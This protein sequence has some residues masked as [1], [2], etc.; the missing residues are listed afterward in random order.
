[1]VIMMRGFLYYLLA[2]INVP[3]VFAGG[4]VVLLVKDH[5]DNNIS[6]EFAMYSTLT[7]LFIIIL[8]YVIL[9]SI[10]YIN[11]RKTPIFY[12]KLIRI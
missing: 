5:V 2:Y 4:E 11:R 12:T 9:K 10:T 8:I 6:R 3:S 7:A 1:M